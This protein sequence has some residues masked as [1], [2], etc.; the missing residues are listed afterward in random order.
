MKPFAALSR[1]S[2]IRTDPQYIMLRYRDP[3]GLALCGSP[4]PPPR[5]VR[6]SCWNMCYENMYNR[7][8][9]QDFRHNFLKPKILSPKP[10]GRHV[11]IAFPGARRRAHLS[12][13]QEH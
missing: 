11:E 10:L 6:A 8:P 4:P 5:C 13:T 3:P 7:D 9:Q 12:Y 2:S 1:A